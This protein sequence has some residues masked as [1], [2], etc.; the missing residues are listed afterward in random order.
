MQTALAPRDFARRAR[1]LY[2]DRE[3][4]VDG[5]LRWTYAEFL[6]RPSH[7]LPGRRGRRLPLHQGTQLREGQWPRE[8]LRGPRGV[9]R[10]E[11]E[12]A[13]RVAAVA[14][15][16]FQPV[17]PVTTTRSGLVLRTTP[18]ARAARA[19]HG[20]PLS[21]PCGS[22]ARRFDFLEGDWNA[23]CRL[24]LPDGT[25]G[26]GAGWPYINAHVCA[27]N[28]GGRVASD[29]STSAITSSAASH[30]TL[31]R[32]NPSLMASPPQRARRSAVE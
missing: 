7:H 31:K 21:R 20:S 8:R 3:A 4:V 14:H 17:G 27:V 9:R 32:M 19:F 1:S 16:E 13:G 18:N 2:A 26:E 24:P 10:R 22:F 6:D 23:L 12:S 25:W 15:A 30:P 11:C 28:T 29:W 5:N